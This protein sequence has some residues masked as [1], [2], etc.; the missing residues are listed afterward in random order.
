MSRLSK[1]FRSSPIRP[2]ARKT[3]LGVEVLG[4]RVVPSVTMNEDASDHSLTITTGLHQNNT[5]TIRNDGV[6]N[7]TVTGDGVTRHFAGVQWVQVSTGDLRDTVTYN[8][9]TA[10]H[11]V[12]TRRSFELDVSLGSRF[13][14][15][16][17]DRFTAN[18]FGDVG[19]RQNGVLRE[20]SLYFNVAGTAGADRVDFNFND[21]DI[22][23]G[24]SLGIDVHGLDGN[25]NITV[26][27]DGELDGSLRIGV[28]GDNGD[29]TIAVNFLLDAG[30]T[31]SVGDDSLTGPIRANVR[32]DLGNDNLRFAI[33][34]AAGSHAAVHATLDGGFGFGFPDLDIGRHTANVH[35]AF[36]EQDIVIA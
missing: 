25:D 6:G 27:M 30:S 7:L 13:D 21:T 34:Q 26:D 15:T 17:Q 29:D 23:E 5:V 12:D 11:E 36:L 20:R 16:D 3:R 1:L 18:V 35:T 9:G 4:D 24:S 28:T 22:H 33:R 14:A 2:S 31:G 8:Q 19:F 32:G 10:G